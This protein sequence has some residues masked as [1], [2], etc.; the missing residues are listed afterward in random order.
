MDLRKSLAHPVLC[1]LVLG[2]K[3]RNHTEMGRTLDFWRCDIYP[4]KG[5][6]FNAKCFLFARLLFFKEY[7]CGGGGFLIVGW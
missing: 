5:V 2:G 3:T 1:L 7:L 4:G 6:F